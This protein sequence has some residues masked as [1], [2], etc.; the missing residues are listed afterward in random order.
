MLVDASNL[1]KKIKEGKNQKT[2]L[3]D[4]EVKKIE[5]TFICQEVIDDFSVKV[6]Y[7]QIIE[8]N[9]SLSAGQYFE[10]RIEY[11]EISEEQFNQNMKG[12]KERLQMLFD[13][14]KTLENSILQDLGD[15]K[16]V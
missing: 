5:D 8:K 7:N 9:Y 3:N 13:E 16:Y 4:Q 11:V 6:S 14:G 12:Y 1:G 2:V 10:I 15:L